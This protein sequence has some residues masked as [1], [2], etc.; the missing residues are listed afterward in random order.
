MYVQKSY[1]FDLEL[2]QY[3]ENVK[4]VSTMDR[5]VKTV[6]MRAIRPSAGKKYEI[7]HDSTPCSP[8][9]L[10][11]FPSSD[12]R[13]HWCNRAIGAETGAFACDGYT[14]H[15]SCVLHEYLIGL[16]SMQKTEVS[17]WNVFYNS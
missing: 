9:Y 10:S 1:K 13:C 4:D 15:S 11:L 3:N 17:S 16:R 7:Q 2:S 5:N 12:C 14:Y 6:S 8:R